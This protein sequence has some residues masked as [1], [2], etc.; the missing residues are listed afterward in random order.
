M[1]DIL[2]RTSAGLTGIVLARS[3]S[4]QRP[5]IRPLSESEGENP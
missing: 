5:A 2:K 3:G 1:K 4:R